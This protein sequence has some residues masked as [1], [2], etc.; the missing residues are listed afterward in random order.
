MEEKQYN[1]IISAKNAAIEVL[2]HNNKGPNRKLPR[3]AGWGYPEPY[4]RDLIICSL[5]NLV[6]NNK[7]LI[8]STKTVLKHLAKN[9]GRLGHIASLVDDPDDFGA[10]DCTPLFLMGVG[11]WRKY[12]GENDFLEKAV[13]KALTWMEYQNPAGRV[14]IGQLPTTDWR[15]EQWVLGYGLFVN[16]IAY[17]YMR[18]F[19]LKKKASILKNEMERFTIKGDIQHKHVHEGLLLR[20][21]PYYALW[22]FKIYRSERFDLLGNSLAILSGIASESRAKEII[23][24][25]E[26]ECDSLRKNGL[27]KSELPPNFFPYIKPDDPDWFP[28]YEKFNKPG[29]YHNGGIWPFICGF[30][31]AALVSAGKIKLA[32]QKLLALTELIKQPREKD[33][34]YG[35]N[36]WHKAQTA[37]PC[38]QDWQS[39]SA[40]MYLYAAQCVLQEKTPFF[41]KLR[42]QYTATD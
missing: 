29:D 23:K 22:S 14:L 42:E 12:S 11:L 36:E 27:L 5:G 17:T 39:W 21:K 1:E 32:Q 4:T 13:E 15:D 33:V 9:Q 30:Y 7:T 18:L 31:I 41:D 16:T 10:D 6:S 3:T 26:E 2:L 24:W 8:D 28:R 34:K 37:K 38:G 19:D 40:A 25:I 35:F 20:H